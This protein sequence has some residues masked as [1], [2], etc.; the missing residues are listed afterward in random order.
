MPPVGSPAPLRIRATMPGQP[1]RVSKS[2]RSAIEQQVGRGRIA[3]AA[4]LQIDLGD[5]AGQRR[6]AGEDAGDLVAVVRLSL[7]L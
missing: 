6:A 2:A 5:R 3:Q 7:A 1:R 4:A